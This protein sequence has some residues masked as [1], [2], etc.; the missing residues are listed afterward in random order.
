MAGLTKILLQLKH[1][2]L[3]P[4]LHSAT[5][6]PHIDFENSPFIV[7]QS[8]APWNRPV[9]TS[10][11]Y[12][13]AYLRRAGISSFGAGGSNAHL[14][15]EELEE[16]L[17]SMPPLPPVNETGAL[18]DPVVIVLSARN[19]NRLQLIAGRLAKTLQQ[20]KYNNQH[21]PSIAYTLQVGRE[22]L[23]TRLA[24]VV[25]SIEEL[26]QKLDDF[27]QQ[28]QVADD[29]YYGKVERDNGAMEALAADEDLREAINK[30]ITRKNTTASVLFW[31][32]GLQVNWVG[33]YAANTLASL[34]RI[35]LPTY[36]FEQERYW[37]P[38]A[39]AVDAPAA[40]AATPASTLLVQPVWQLQPLPAAPIAAQYA[41]HII[42]LAGMDAATW[43][44]SL[45][46]GF[47]RAQVIN[48]YDPSQDIQASYEAS[49]FQL[50]QLVQTLL[51]DRPT[52]KIL[53]QVV[54]DAGHDTLTGLFALLQTAR[55]ENPLITGQLIGITQPIDTRRLIA[56]L[57]ENRLSS[58]QAAIR[59]VN[60][61]RYELCWQEYRAGH[62]ARP[63][64]KEGGVI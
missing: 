63:L 3:A 57:Q 10:N 35:S 11:G 60:E 55:Q 9:I 61:L 23:D 53:I 59:Y 5:L 4:S 29:L 46:E 30:W 45:K 31:V 26:C 44:P 47:N 49:S 54:V 6:N 41:Q 19:E 40:P 56:L 17:Q 32:K 37:V 51:Q 8:L 62:S 28:G 7:Q 43:L 25:R 12:T 48:C 22:A 24:L 14:I 16:H 2:Q 64:W 18:V 52:H 42:F 39:T 38:Q 34:R 27:V 1:R 36:P 21:L 20:G 13:T 33:L 15:I 58:N 50:F